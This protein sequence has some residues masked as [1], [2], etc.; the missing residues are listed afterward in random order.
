IADAN[1]ITAEPADPL[2]S[3]EVG[4]AYE[5]PEVIRS[6][7]SASTFKPYELAEIIGNDRPIAI[8]PPPPPKFS[9]I[10]QLLIAAVSITV[11][12]GAPGVLTAWGVPP[13][14]SAAI[15][16]GLGDLTGQGTSWELGMRAPGQDAIDWGGVGIAAMEGYLVSVTSL[17]L[18]SSVEIPEENPVGA[19]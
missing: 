5:I 10:E 2:P 7:Q 3:S 12:V 13:P 4:K 19:L 1:S 8:P 15:G 18:D 17:P 9:D 6:S 11:Q 16:A 14:V